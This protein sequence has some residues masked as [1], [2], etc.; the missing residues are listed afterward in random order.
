[1]ALAVT[2]AAAGDPSPPGW[3]EGQP[4]W[5]IALYILAGLLTTLVPAWL[6]TRRVRTPASE[7]PESTPADTT[8]VSAGPSPMPQTAAP[9]ERYDA[10]MALIE[11]ML[12]NV[13]RDQ[14]RDR[15]AAEQL[16]IKNEELAGLV[17]QLQVALQ[18]RDLTIAQ[19]HRTIDRLLERP[20]SQGPAAPWPGPTPRPRPGP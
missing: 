10:K 15:A 2:L 19:L 12:D 7:P 16:R 13:E 3:L 17:S 5:L 9:A 11:K 1:M 8:T 6:L 18:G 4:P 14:E 20:S